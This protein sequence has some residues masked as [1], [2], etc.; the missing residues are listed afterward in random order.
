MRAIWGLFT[1]FIWGGGGGVLKQLVDVESPKRLPARESFACQQ[2]ASAAARSERL[3]KTSTAGRL[4]MAACISCACTNKSCSSETHMCWSLDTLKFVTSSLEIRLS[5][6]ARTMLL[7]ALAETSTS[8]APVFR[9]R[10]RLQL[11]DPHGVPAESFALV[12]VS[13]VHRREYRGRL[14]PHRLEETSDSRPSWDDLWNSEL[15]CGSLVQVRSLDP[16]R[17]AN[18]TQPIRSGWFGRDFF[19]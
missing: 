8:S 19:A 6:Q 11:Q 14:L 10:P 7:M 4:G 12:P 5:V 2:L 1:V 13:R 17:K 16:L 9:N 15:H 18:H 3:S